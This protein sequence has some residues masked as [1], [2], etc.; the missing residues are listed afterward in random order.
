MNFVLSFPE[1]TLNDYSY[2]MII[3]PKTMKKTRATLKMTCCD[4]QIA[5]T[6]VVRNI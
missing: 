2:L 4:S 6:F 5:L 1:K 3:N